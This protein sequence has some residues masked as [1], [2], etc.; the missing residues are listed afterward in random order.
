MNWYEIGAIIGVISGILG[1][2]TKIKTV[3]VK[4]NTVLDTVESNTCKLN[5]LKED[6]QLNNL[7]T[8][9]VLQTSILQSDILRDIL[10]QHI[11]QMTNKI[12]KRGFITDEEFYCLRKL[13]NDYKMVNGNSTV[14]VRVE[15]AFGMIK[16][17]GEFPLQN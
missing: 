3:L 11:I 8:E 6:L 12:F 17:A 13:Y 14:D 5:Q 15:K 2:L 16:E 9:E 7:K 10:R 4:T 1:I